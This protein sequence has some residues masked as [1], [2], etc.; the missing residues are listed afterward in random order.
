M[1]SAY[2]VDELKD[3]A[4]AE[5]A[6]AFLAKPLDIDAV[7]RLIG[8]LRD[9]AILIVADDQQTVAQL[10][11]LLEKNGFRV[12]VVRTPQAALEIV[13]QTRF[14]I[15][16][17]DAR[18]P[19]TDGLDLGLAVRKLTPS[20]VAIMLAGRTDQ[21]ARLPEASGRPAYTI[22][23]KPLDT[24]RVLQL[25]EELTGPRPR[26]TAPRPVAGNP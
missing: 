6:I 5:G 17:I 4:L 2:N 22:L 14:D 24:Q 21:S 10:C 12:T 19:A 16:F 20:A 8:A 1:M 3:A 15:I 26:E 18:L 23:A 9:R 13:E 25:L 11:G 7:I